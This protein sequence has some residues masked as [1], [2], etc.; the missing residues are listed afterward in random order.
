MRCGQTYRQGFNEIFGPFL[1]LALRD[2]LRLSPAV[3]TDL[4]MYAP[5]QNSGFG[6]QQ[7]EDKIDQ[8]R[9]EMLL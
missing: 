3:L 9:V 7:I 2:H 6:A 1:W 4:R 8:E 5:T